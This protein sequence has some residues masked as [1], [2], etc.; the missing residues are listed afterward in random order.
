MSQTPDFTAHPEPNAPGRPPRRATSGG[1]DWSTPET[2]DSAADYAAPPW[3]QQQP[4]APPGG[5]AAGRPPHTYPSAETAAPSGPASGPPP[6]GQ[7]RRFALLAGGAVVLALAAGGLLYA[8]TSGGSGGSG[9][10][11]AGLKVLFAAMGT[12]GTASSTGLAGSW[13][14]AHTVVDGRADGLI[15]WSYAKRAQVWNWHVPGGQLGCGMSS[16]PVGGVGVVAYGADRNTC[17]QLA[18]I[19]VDTGKQ[20]WGPISL[21]DTS[22]FPI[23]IRNPHISVAGAVLAAQGPQG[24]ITAYDLATGA[25]KWSTPVDTNLADDTCSIEDVEALPTTVYGLYGCEG[26]TSGSYTKLV[27]Y[28]ANSGAQTWKGDLSQVPATSAYALSL[29]T[30]DSAGA[31]LLVDSTPHHEGLYAFLRGAATPVHID[32]TTYNY[33]AFSGTGQAQDQ[34]RPHGYAIAGHTLY[35]EN[36][37][38]IHDIS[39]PITALDLNTGRKL[40]TQDLGGGIAS[41]IISADAR[42]LHTILEIPGQSEYELAVYDPATGKVAKGPGTTDGRF[43]FTADSALYLQGDYLVELPASVLPGTPELLVLTGASR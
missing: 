35:I 37:S 26:L 27:G 23:P 13:A 25:H 6:R 16:A 38:P 3:Y 21:K 5:S 30:A 7:R 24:T 17:D 34:R 1:L 33:N 22:R 11:P 39:N 20:V 4:A 43:T 18:G 36:A 28:D 9:A 42:G 15:A 14:T 29:W 10:S 40:W 32:L 41:T 12:E 8:A 19:D 2:S 31:L